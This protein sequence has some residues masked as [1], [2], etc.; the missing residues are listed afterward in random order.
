MQAQLINTFRAHPSAIKTI[1][2]LADKPLIATGGEDKIIKI[3]TNG[4]DEV[5]HEMTG[6][7]AP[8]T[9]LAGFPNID[10]LVS[11]G[12]DCKIS[13]WNGATGEPIR[14]LVGHTGAVTALVTTLNGKI[15]VSGSADNTVRIWD[16]LNGNQLHVCEGHSGVHAL[17]ISPDAK[18]VVAGESGLNGQPYY[19]LKV[20]DL[21][22]G[23][24]VR[25]FAQIHHGVE[26]I[27][28][29]ESGLVLMTSSTEGDITLWDWETGEIIRTIE[30]HLGSVTTAFTPNRRY[31]IIGTQRPILTIWS[32]ETGRRIH[33]LDEPSDWVSAVAINQSGHYI[34]AGCHDGMLNI[35]RLQHQ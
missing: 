35:Y 27:K 19:K 3:W 12:E 21:K 7:D 9:S 10:F 16:S 23:E 32:I 25:D 14:D 4:N 2:T 20:W 18:Y 17:A 1:V 5:L 34:V 15:I 28:F 13:L 11:G 24:N 29:S 33:Q 26:T 22:T 30:T 8:I 6:H 31:A